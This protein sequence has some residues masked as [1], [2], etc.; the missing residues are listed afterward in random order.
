MACRLEYVLD[1]I[2]RKSRPTDLADLI[3]RDARGPDRWWWQ[4]LV[5]NGVRVDRPP[6][7]SGIESV[8]R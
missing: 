4:Y 3:A 7:V 8:Y 6:A 1:D 2:D 5:I